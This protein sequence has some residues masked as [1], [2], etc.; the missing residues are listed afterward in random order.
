MLEEKEKNSSQD[1][2][3]LLFEKVKEVLRLAN[4]YGLFDSQEKLDSSYSQQ[5]KSEVFSISVTL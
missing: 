1:I 2:E 3:K 4:L 5:G